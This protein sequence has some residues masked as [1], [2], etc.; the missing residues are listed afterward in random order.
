MKVTLEVDLQPFMVPNFVRVVSKPGRKEDGVQELPCYPLS[1][2]DSL[3]LDKLCRQ[4]RDEVFRKAG[5][6]QPAEYCLAT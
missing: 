5:K 4:F 2:L 6:E 3:T 1:D